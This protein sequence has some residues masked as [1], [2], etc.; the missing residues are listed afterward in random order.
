MAERGVIDYLTHMYGFEGSG[1]FE[2]R[3]LR[4]KDGTR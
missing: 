3:A 2:L 1:R 4:L